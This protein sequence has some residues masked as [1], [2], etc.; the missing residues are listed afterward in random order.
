MAVLMA[1]L[2][3]V[4]MA[5]DR[6][7]CPDGCTDEEPQH[8]SAS[9]TPSVCALCHGWSGPTPAGSVEPAAHPTDPLAVPDAVDLTAHLP[10]IDHPPRVA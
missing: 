6:V 7:A 2:L 8:R 3:A 5:A 4:V 9:S 10:A 1:G